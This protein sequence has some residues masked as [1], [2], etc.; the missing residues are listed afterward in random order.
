M[1]LVKVQFNT[2]S[3]ILKCIYL[4]VHQQL[5]K[6]IGRIKKKEKAV[7]QNNFTYIPKTLVFGLFQN[8]IVEEQHTIPIREVLG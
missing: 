6:N 5:V 3:S 7:S 2:D 8:E 1:I 4:N